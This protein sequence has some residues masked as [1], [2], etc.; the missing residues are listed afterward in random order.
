MFRDKSLNI[1]PRWPRTHYVEQTNQEVHR[2]LP[3]CILRAE[4]QPLRPHPTYLQVLYPWIYVGVV[5]DIGHETRNWERKTK[6]HRI[7]EGAMGGAIQCVRHE[8]RNYRVQKGSVKK[9]QSGTE[10]QHNV[11][12]NVLWIPNILSQS[13][14]EKWMA[15]QNYSPRREQDAKIRNWLAFSSL[16]I[17]SDFSV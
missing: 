8:S 2:Y 6:Q 17:T 15:E 7:W 9:E 10:G 5:V 11:D 4:S 14:F 13:F 1:E 16:L 12:E 3:V